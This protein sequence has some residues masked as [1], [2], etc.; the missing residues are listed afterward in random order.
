MK[1]VD[2]V[3]KVGI[4]LLSDLLNDKTNLATIDLT[5]CMNPRE[6]IVKIFIIKKAHDE[7]QTFESIALSK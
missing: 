5:G 6:I 2:V 3:P 4:R 1:R 7:G